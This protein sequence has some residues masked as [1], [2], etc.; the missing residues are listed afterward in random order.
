MRTTFLTMAAVAAMALSLQASAA[1]PIAGTLTF[2]DL[3][4]SSVG[5]HLPAGFG[6]FDWGDRWYYMTRA[7]TPNETFLA[8][9]TIGSTLIRR[10]DGADFHFDGADFHSRRAA[11][12]S[13]DFFFVL[14]HEGRTVYQ[15]NLLGNEGRMRFTG[16]PTLLTPGYSGPIDGMAFGFDNDD[17]DHLAMDNFRFRAQVAAPLLVPEPENWVLMAAGL[18]LVSGLAGRHKRRGVWSHRSSTSSPQQA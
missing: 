6:G 9:S 18:G 14:Y 1:D 11:D 13:G 5:T 4:Q 17:Y 8:T 15:G 12:A 10:S 2:D 7:V 16:T 3:G